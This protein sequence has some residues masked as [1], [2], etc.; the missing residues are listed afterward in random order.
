MAGNEGT[1]GVT[2]TV[3]NGR[4]LVSRGNSNTA[5]RKN[6]RT[7]DE[8]CAESACGVGSALA[9]G[10]SSGQVCDSFRR[11]C[12]APC[13]S[14]GC[15]AGV[16]CPQGSI[17]VPKE[18]RC[19]RVAGVGC[20]DMSTTWWTGRIHLESRSRSPQSTRGV[21]FELQNNSRAPLYFRSMLQRRFLFDV[22]AEVCG[23]ERKLNLAENDWCPAQCP[24]M[25]RAYERDCRKLPP[26]VQWLAA[27]ETLSMDWSGQEQVGIRRVCEG[28]PDG[29]C[30]EQRPS[31][32]GRYAVE[33]CGFTD[34]KGGHADRDEPDRWVGAETSGE[35][36]CRRVGFEYPA[37]EPVVIEFG[38]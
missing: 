13:E 33:V 2:S 9:G 12:V 23:M 28:V 17:C 4:L 30:V 3:E 25:G 1:I 34:V 36:R 6:P 32:H 21:V 11:I 31:R 27:G 37:T 5:S 26:S 29:Y 38:T 8:F 18:G 10:C 14:L 15:C 19:G 20:F 7:V 24:E 22:Y 16:E 35:E